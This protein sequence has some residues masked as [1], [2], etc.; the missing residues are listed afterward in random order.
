M[1]GA[2]PRAILEKGN[3]DW[4]RP[5]PGCTGYVKAVKKKDGVGAFGSCDQRAYGDADSCP[6]TTTI[7]QASQ[8][9]LKFC[10]ICN[11]PVRRTPTLGQ[12]TDEKDDRGYPGE[13]LRFFLTQFQTV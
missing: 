13:F 5:S 1:G 6:V 3:P 2:K 11:A 7:L 4:P 12:P 10:V 9:H 8:D